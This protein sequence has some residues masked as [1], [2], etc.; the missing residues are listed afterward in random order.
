LRIARYVDDGF[1]RPFLNSIHCSFRPGA[2]GS[3]TIRSN[4]GV[5]ED[6]IDCIQEE[7]SAHMAWMLSNPAPTHWR[8]RAGQ[9]DAEL[10]TAGLC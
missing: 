7:T 1:R 4:P 9:A 5:V 2:R 3:S 10:S 6:S 8:R